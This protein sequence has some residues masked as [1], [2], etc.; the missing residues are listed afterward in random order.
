[1]SANAKGLIATARLVSV[2][3]RYISCCACLSSSAN[4]KCS[5]SCSCSSSLC[6]ARSAS[7]HCCTAALMAVLAGKLAATWRHN[8]SA[9]PNCTLCRIRCALCCHCRLRTK[10]RHNRTSR[11]IAAVISI[12]SAALITLSNTP[13]ITLVCQLCCTASPH[14]QT[15][16]NSIASNVAPA[17][18]HH[19]R[20]V[21][22]STWAGFA[23]SG[24]ITSVSS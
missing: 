22:R 15:D 20:P 8:G 1:M 17:S 21:W 13:C 5:N 2:A 14:C 16:N 3:A 9:S 4:T 12:S 6:C 7:C 11:H 24:A 19:H 10:R 18:R 23:A